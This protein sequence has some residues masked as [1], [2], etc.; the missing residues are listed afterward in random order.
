MMQYYDVLHTLDGRSITNTTLKRMNAVF[1]IADYDGGGER[2]AFTNLPP[3]IQKQFGFDPAKAQ[4]ELDLARKKKEEAAQHQGEL[5]QAQQESQ[6]NTVLDKT[7]RW[8]DESAVPITDF[9]LRYGRISLVLTNGILLIPYVSER[10]AGHAP[11]TANQSAGAYIGPGG[12]GGTVEKLGNKKVFIKCPIRGIQAG[13]EWKGL[14]YRNGTF[15]LIANQAGTP[16]EK[17]DCGLS[18]LTKSDVVLKSAER[19]WHNPRFKQN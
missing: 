19:V 12:G 15:T 18:Y 2:I 8:V 11:V 14:C 9:R 17:Y 1:A 4:E 5:A 6:Q 10:V 3:E 13:A 16:Y 7:L